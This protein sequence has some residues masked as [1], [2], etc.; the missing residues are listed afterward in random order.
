MNALIMPP[1]IQQ[2]YSHWMGLSR[3]D[4]NAVYLARMLASVEQGH[5]VLSDTLGLTDDRYQTLIQRYFP[6]KNKCFQTRLAEPLGE[7]DNQG[8]SNEVIQL[9]NLLLGYRAQRSNSE[10]ALARI[11]ACACGGSDHLWYDL[12]LWSRDDLNALLQ[13]NFPDLV[14]ANRFNMRWK[15]FLYRQLC[16]ESN[17]M[18]CRSPNCR[19]CV[20]YSECFIPG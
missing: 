15:K 5:S 2:R 17:V 11:I 4:F 1:R 10:Y 18:M 8:V 13:H 6:V 9:T 7:L 16:L 14:K 3:G 20:D 19:D 12:G